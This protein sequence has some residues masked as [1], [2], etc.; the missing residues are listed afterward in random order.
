MR[1]YEAV[2]VFVGRSVLHLLDSKILAVY[3]HGTPQHRSLKTENGPRETPHGELFPIASAESKKPAR[4][5]RLWDG[6][7]GR[8]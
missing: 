7:P 8:L 5:Q 1:W 6:P 2:K 4:E 3:D